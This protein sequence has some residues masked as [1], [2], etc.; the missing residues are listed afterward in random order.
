MNDDLYVFGG[1]DSKEIFIFIIEK[2]LTAA[3]A[4]VS[5]LC[6]ILNYVSLWMTPVNNLEKNLSSYFKF[7]ETLFKYFRLIIHEAN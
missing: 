1:Y 6:I 4:Y 3:K 5:L 2:Y 7:H